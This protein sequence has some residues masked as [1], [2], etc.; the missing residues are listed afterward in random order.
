MPPNEGA[1]YPSFYEAIDGIICVLFAATATTAA[2]T[3][4]FFLR[5]LRFR[6]SGSNFNFLAVLVQVTFSDDA[7]LVSSPQHKIPFAMLVG[8][9]WI[10]LVVC[11]LFYCFSI[12]S[13]IRGW[14]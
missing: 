6:Y 14:L 5:L 1:R 10:T 11:I 12:A 2:A 9:F 8:F 7:I 13:K 4:P 3:F